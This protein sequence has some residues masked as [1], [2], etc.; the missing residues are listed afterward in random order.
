MRSE[1][2]RCLFLSGE[3]GIAKC[4][5]RSCS[6]HQHSLKNEDWKPRVEFLGAPVLYVCNVFVLKNSFLR[7]LKNEELAFKHMPSTQ[8]STTPMPN[9]AAYFLQ[10]TRI[11]MQMRK[12]SL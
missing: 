8:T 12:N 2:P 7:S 10:T 1:V 9:L 5:K 4:L 3:E 11:N 6:N